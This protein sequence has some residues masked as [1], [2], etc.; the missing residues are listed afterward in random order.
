MRRR[1]FEGPAFSYRS[2]R[3][4]SLMIGLGLV[5]VIETAV[6]HLW[7]HQRH[8]A[9]AWCLTIVSLMGLAWLAADYQRLGCGAITL[10]G[11]TLHLRVGLRANAEIRLGAVVSAMHPTWR[12]IPSPSSTEEREYRNLMKPSSPNVLIVLDKPFQLK[13]AHTVPVSVLRIGL[14]LDDPDGF[15]A[16]INTAR[17][18]ADV[19]AI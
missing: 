16:A 19:A 4:G 2:A 1:L 13:I 18:S 15:L 3:S 12:D 8:P 14:Y 11:H 5:I 7:L 6:L 9:A 17:A 10:D